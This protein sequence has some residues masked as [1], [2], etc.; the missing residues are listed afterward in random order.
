MHH[1]KWTPSTVHERLC[2]ES[3]S[4]V[5]LQDYCRVRK[6]QHLR[7]F[8][9][10]D[11]LIKHL[12]DPAGGF[13]SKDRTLA[14]LVSKA[15][16]KHPGTKRCGTTLIL[17][18][19][20]PAL[21]HSVNKLRDLRTAFP[22][23]FSEL[24]GA[25]F[26]EIGHPRARRTAK[27]AINLQM[28]AE[29]RVRQKAKAERDYQSQLG[30]YRGFEETNDPSLLQHH[31]NRGFHLKNSIAHIEDKS[32]RRFMRRPSEESSGLSAPDKSQLNE[33]LTK[34][35]KAGHISRKEYGVLKNHALKDRSLTA[36]AK[37]RRINNSTLRSRLHRCR[38]K[39]IKCCT[40]D[41]KCN[42]SSI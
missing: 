37:H 18:S 32:A 23:L 22:D 24:F 7:R 42:E 26:D 39:L 16:G 20:W 1:D 28:N 36:I 12:H 19:M 15:N 35:W 11:D 6:H 30:L 31:K 40:P 4:P 9:T 41:D 25:M 2:S 38:E 14:A 13:L 34:L 21:N 8:Q 29:K 17:L 33:T 5:F 27:V 10:P 3:K